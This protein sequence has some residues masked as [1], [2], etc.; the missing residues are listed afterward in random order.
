MEQVARR[1]FAAYGL[2]DVVLQA[3]EAGYRNT[4]FAAV[5]PDGGAA[6]NLIMYKHEPDIQ[7]RVQ[8]ANRVGNYLAKQGLPARQTAD[9]GILIMKTTTTTRYASLYYYLPGAT[10][11]WDAY[12]KHHIKLLGHAM[13][14]MHAATIRYVADAAPL[15][16]DEYLAICKRMKAYVAE[17]GV[18]AAM[19]NKL[20]LAPI[21]LGVF[22]RFNQSITA[23]SQLPGQRML[24]MDLVRSNVL[25]AP[26]TPGADLQDGPVQL[27][28]IL[29]FEKTAYGHPV[30][31]LART[32]AFLL[33]DCKYKPADKIEKYFVRSGYAKRGH[34]L[35]PVISLPDGSDL[36]HELTTLFL[37]YD[38][39]KFL[40]HNPYES[41]ADNEH[42]MRTRDILIAR[43]VLSAL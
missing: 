15:V 12:T 16:S 34:G 43:K 42:F 6:V 33:V 39:Y 32:L 5:R 23:S 35:I 41:L 28:G 31:D 18:V 2:T 1:A 17:P 19:A 36:F 8:R 20:R 37:L 24:H 26:A 7:Q 30:Y 38:F 11:P 21:D 4:S 27:T 25:F 22:E 10:I 14:K 29:D 40:R 9:P 3:P 13:G